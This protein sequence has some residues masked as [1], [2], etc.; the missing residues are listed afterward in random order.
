MVTNIRPGAVI[1]TGNHKRLANFYEGITGLTVSFADDK[2][3][4]LR[5]DSFELVIHALPNEAS[6]SAV[7]ELPHVGQDSYIKLFF[8]VPSLSEARE[9]A[10]ALGGELR[11]A[12]EEWTA[13]GFRACE[14]ID[15]DG[16]VIQFREEDSR[17]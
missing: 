10:A 12:R 5:S 14:A 7:D 17:G 11:P 9:R 13:R 4:V 16:N 15:P 1:F 8:P 2:V 3:T 6:E